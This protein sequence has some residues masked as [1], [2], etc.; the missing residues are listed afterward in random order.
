MLL[1]EKI[2]IACLLK[3][4]DSLHQNLLFQSTASF[5]YSLLKLV[6]YLDL[7]YFILENVCSH[8]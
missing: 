2:G 3:F 1:N 8:K 5:K 4:L 6:Q 7:T